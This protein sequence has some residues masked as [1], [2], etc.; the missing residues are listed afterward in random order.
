MISFFLKKFLVAYHYYN[1][2][3]IHHH[4][5]YNLVPP[6]FLNLSQHISHYNTPLFPTS[7]HYTTSHYITY[8][9]TQP[10]NT[11]LLPL[12]ISHI[13]TIPTP[14]HITT[15]HTS[16]YHLTT[17][18]YFTSPLP[19]LILQHPQPTQSHPTSH[20]NTTYILTSPHTSSHFTLVPF[21]LSHQMSP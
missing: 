6:H 19:H 20:H 15:P 9:H 2:H 3:T 11:T 14:P 4:T 7:H 12:T 16:T 1:I 18:H 8:N 10:Y 13:T 5:T 17:S 21:N